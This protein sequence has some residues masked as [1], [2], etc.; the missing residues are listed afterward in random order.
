MAIELADVEAAI[1]RLYL[2]AGASATKT[3]KRPARSPRFSAN[4]PAPAYATTSC[5]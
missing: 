2:G 1:G 5:W 3:A 4:S